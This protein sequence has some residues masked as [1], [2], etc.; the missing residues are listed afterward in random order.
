VYDLMPPSLTKTRKAMVEKAF[1][2]GKSLEF[3][4]QRAGHIFENTLYP[5]LDEEGKVS[6]MA[7]YGRI[8][9]KRVLAYQRLDEQKGMLATK[10]AQLQDANTALEVLLQK[11][12]QR[13]EMIEEKFAFS[14]RKL[15]GP[16]IQKLKTCSLTGT[17]KDCVTRIDEN[18][19]ILTSP[20]SRKLSFDY[21]KL[22]PREI[23]VADLIISGKTTKE[24]SEELN[25]TKGTIDF[26]RNSIREKLALK[27]KKINLRTY[28]RS[29]EK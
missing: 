8:I 18:L 5:S 3:E 14:T 16:Y 9:T 29:R 17:A 28:L 7:V 19:N 25:L 10:T 21:V 2:T 6:L 23:Q 22:T 15:I 26:Y 24:I 12:S 1:Q 4:D 27:K 13:E 20:F 11:A